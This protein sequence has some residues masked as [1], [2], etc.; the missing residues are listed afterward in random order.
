MLFKNISWNTF[1]AISLNFHWQAI[2]TTGCNFS[3]NFS[4]DYYRI[5]VFFFFLIFFQTKKQQQVFAEKDLFARLDSSLIVNWLKIINFT[6]IDSH[7]TGKYTDVIWQIGEEDWI[8]GLEDVAIYNIID[9]QRM[10]DMLQSKII[11]KG[12]NHEVR[13]LRF[14]NFQTLLPPCSFLNN[15][16]TS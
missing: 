10:H 1:T 11:I 9:Y 2:Y 5:Y 3:L 14:C 4:L 7:L 13:T 8:F 15:R 16:M 6:L 12:T